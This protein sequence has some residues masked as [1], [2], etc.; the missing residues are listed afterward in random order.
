MNGAEPSPPSLRSESSGLRV[1]CARLAL[2][3]DGHLR[4]AF[5][6]VFALLNR[7]SDRPPEPLAHVYSC[8][9]RQG[10]ASTRCSGHQCWNSDPKINRESKAGGETDKAAGQTEGS[11][12]SIMVT[13]QIGIWQSC[14]FCSHL[15]YRAGASFLAI[16]SRRS[17]PI[18][19]RPYP[20]KELRSMCSVVGVVA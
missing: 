6:E 11:G 10:A 18:T 2:V 13:T 12:V 4:G 8:E 9:S 17:I 3:F 20:T 16:G 15:F 7:Q 1:Q 5:A 19:G 14:H